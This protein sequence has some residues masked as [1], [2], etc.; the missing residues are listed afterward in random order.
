MQFLYG[1]LPSAVDTLVHDVYRD[2]L[3]GASLSVFSLA[4][5]GRAR[6]DCYASLLGFDTG[7][8]PLTAAYSAS[9]W[10]ARS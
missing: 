2:A 5:I 4:V 1:R 7:H 8:A 6:S 10:F 3:V 9:I